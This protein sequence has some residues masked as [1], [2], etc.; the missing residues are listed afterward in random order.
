MLKKI[1]F[2]QCLNNACKSYTTISSSSSRSTT[3]TMM[4]IKTPSS[5]SSYNTLNRVSQ[6]Y[7]YN[8]S[9][10]LSSHTFNNTRVHRFCTSNNNNISNDNNIV[11]NE[12]VGTHIESLY[13]VKVNQESLDRLFKDSKMQFSESLLSLQST[14]E[15]KIGKQLLNT[16]IVKYLSVHYPNMTEYFMDHFIRFISLPVVVSNYFLS[17]QFD[18]YLHSKIPQ[19]TSSI[20][21]VKIYN[22]LFLNLIGTIAIQTND[23]TIIEKEIIGGLIK[24]LDG[25]SFDQVSKQYK[26]PVLQDL[27]LNNLDSKEILVD[28]PHIPPWFY[29]ICQLIIQHIDAFTTLQAV[30]NE[31]SLSKAHYQLVKEVNRG[32]AKSLFFH[33]IYLIKPDE[34]TEIIGY[35]T[36]KSIEKSKTN[37]AKDAVARFLYLNSTK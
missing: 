7:C 19:E 1:V 34:T 27:A 20:D 31:H 21:R 5:S 16:G 3:T 14:P 35:G 32:T 30:L 9:S 23:E 24:Y 26:L 2:N 33:V 28:A 11:Q 8:S 10:I 13:K 17:N 36:G 37:T 15:Y 29:S 25:L 4:M 6:G 18:Q 22:T 12:D